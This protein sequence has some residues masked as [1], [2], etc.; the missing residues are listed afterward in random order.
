MTEK[1]K[2]DE[3]L[4]ILFLCRQHRQSCRLRQSVRRVSGQHRHGGFPGPSAE[5]RAEQRQPGD[6]HPAQPH[7]LHAAPR[8]GLRRAQ[9]GPGAHSRQ[10]ERR[11]YRRAA[12]PGL[13]VLRPVLAQQERRRAERFRGHRGHVRFC[14]T[15]SSF[16]WDSSGMSPISSRKIVPFVATSK[17]P[18]DR[19][20]SRCTARACTC[21]W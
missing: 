5:P 16:A 13:P 14:S 17:K 21:R 10:L 11:V 19:P 6:D 1:E 18:S 8:P 3:T 9:R 4:A 12:G 2:P 15:R 7:E 20:S